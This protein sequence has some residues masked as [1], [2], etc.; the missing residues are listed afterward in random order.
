MLIKEHNAHAMAVAEH[1]ANV[2]VAEGQQE[3]DLITKKIEVTGDVAARLAESSGPSPAGQ[4]AG[5]PSSSAAPQ[6]SAPPP[7]V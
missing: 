6:P 3:L 2:R 1:D 5:V 4:N 7:S